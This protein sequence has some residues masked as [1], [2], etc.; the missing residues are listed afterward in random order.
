MCA[1]QCQVFEVKPA[2]IRSHLYGGTEKKIDQL[3]A[4]LKQAWKQS[5]K[6]S[7]LF[8]DEVDVM[9]GTH[10]HPHEATISAIGLFKQQWDGLHACNGV[11]VIGTT[12]HINLLGKAV[13]RRFDCTMRVCSCK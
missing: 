5:Q 9:L 8:L 7:V 12:N 13:V 2:Q 1:Q 4:T 10:S 3:F 6:V 11:Y